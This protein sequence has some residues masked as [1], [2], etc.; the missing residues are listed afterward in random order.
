[1]RKHWCILLVTAIIVLGSIK[2]TLSD[3]IKH[4]VGVKPTPFYVDFIG[5]FLI[6]GKDCKI[7]DE[8]GVFN[9]D[10]VLCGAFVVRKP[11]QYG[12]L[13]V[14]GDDKT[15]TEIDGALLGNELTF[16]VW[17]SQ[18]KIEHTISPDEMTILLT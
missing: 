10:K 2:I 4:F 9:K 11:G 14:Y 5:K 6:K 7:G 18:S 13:H 1:M 3:S 16:V 12:I 15:T 17:D 8:V